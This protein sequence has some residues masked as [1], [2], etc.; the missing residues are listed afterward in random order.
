MRPPTT[1]TASA[2][3]TTSPSTT[4]VTDVPADARSSTPGWSTALTS[5]TRWPRGRGRRPDP[6]AS[7]TSALTQVAHREAPM[8]VSRRASALSAALSVALP[9]RIVF[10]TGI[11]P[12]DVGG[13]ATHGPEF[14]ALSRRSRARGRR[15]HD[16]RRGARGAAVRGRRRLPLVAVPGALRRGVAAIAAQRARR[17]DVVYA[18]ATYAAAGVAASV[19]RT[20]LVAKLVSDPA[21]E[22]GR[23]YGLFDGTLEEFQQPGSAACE[24]LKRR[25]RGRCAGPGRSS[26]RAPTSPRSP[27]AGASIARRVTVLPNPAPRCDVGPVDRR[28]GDVRLRRAADPAEGAGRSRSTAIGRVPEARLVVIGDGPDRD[29]LEAVARSS[30]GRDRI[31]FLRLGSAERGAR[32][33]RRR[34][35][36]AAHERLGELP[37]LCRRGAVRR[38]AGSLDGRGRRPGDRARRR[39]RPA[40][41]PG[42]RRRGRRR[43]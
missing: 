33:R 6:A 38:R 7:L 34:R 43:R 22:R 27:A 20:P 36:G 39:E 30:G 35:G 1:V 17:A 13:P 8:I 12:P 42:E 15:R 5:E 16:G 23:R 25:A 24:A 32:D 40:R 26:S 37:A 29:A 28:A 4:I 31:A 18:T 10:L 19:A 14:C 41:A 9:M 11:W 3:S 21:Y 2:A